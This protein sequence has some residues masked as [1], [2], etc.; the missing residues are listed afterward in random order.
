[1]NN[2][3]GAIPRILSLGLVTLRENCVLPMLVN[4]NFDRDA[5]KKGSS[6]DVPVYKSVGKA[7]DVVPSATFSQPED[8]R[9]EYVPIM[10]DR[11]KT[12]D[13]YLTDKDI[14][15]IIEGVPENLQV[16]EAARSLANAV[17]EDLFSLYKQIYNFTGVPGQTPF[18]PQPSAPPF[19]LYQGTNVASDAKRLL[20]LANAPRSNRRIVLD[21]EAEAKASALPEFIHADKSGSTDGIREGYIGRKMGFDWEM[22]QNA[23]YHE[24]GAT[25]GTAFTVN[26]ATLKEAT[27]I[28]VAGA[29]TPPVEGDVLAIAGHKT[30]YVVKEGSTLTSWLIAPALEK[31]TADGTAITVKDSHA[32]NLAFH[33]DAMACVVRPLA[34]INPGNAVIETYTDDIS[35]LTLRLEVT[36]GSKETIWSFDILYGVKMLRPELAV[37][38]AG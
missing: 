20:N 15:E 14:G 4:R 10:L 33:R 13:F 17:D 28:T 8:S 32:V 26:G 21:V 24:T 1:M 16:S 36:R 35:G 34:D 30:T 25:T 22:D 38:I 23:L 18:Q 19:Q 12:K 9:I 5:R 27:V 29:T 31:N 3:T 37:R 7:R 11:W 6:V 2:L